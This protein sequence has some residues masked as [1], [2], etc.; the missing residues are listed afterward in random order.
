MQNGNDTP[1]PSRPRVRG[2]AAP[3]GSRVVRRVGDGRAGAP[4]LFRR[5]SV[6]AAL[7]LAF[8]SCM[9]FTTARV[10]HTRSQPA[11][12]LS[13]ALP[14]PTTNPAKYLVLMV[15]DGAR[16]DYFTSTA[17]PHFQQLA[18]AGTQ[19]SAGIDG[20]LEAETP[21]AHTAIATGSRPDHNGILGFDWAN[22]DN[23]RYSLFN[24]DKMNELEQI[25][26]DNHAPTIAGLYKQKY[27][28]SVAVSMSGS[29]YYAAAPLGGPTADAIIY[30]GGVCVQHGPNKNC[31]QS[32]FE[33]YGV[34]G[35][36]PP[37][38]V[39]K[40]P[41]LT[42]H[43]TKLASGQEDHTVTNM[44]LATISQM[45]PRLLLMNYPEFDWPLGHVFGG[46]ADPSLVQ[47]DMRD[48]DTD[49]GQIEDAY[50]RAGI[51]NQTLFV[52]T[53]DHGMMPIERWV[54]SATIDN[55]ITAAGTTSPDVASN[56]GDY[57][58]LADPTKAQTVAD[59]IMNANDPGIMCAYYLGGTTTAPAYSPS[60]SCNVDPAIETANQYLLS[61]L[62]NGHEPQVVVLGNEGVSFSDPVSTHWKG[63]HGGAS[64][65]SQH[66]PLI[67]A[68][69]GVKQGV[70][71][72]SPVQTED[73]APTVLAAM[74]VT[75]TGMDGTILSD[76]LQQPT[77]P[78]TKARNGEITWLTP[79]EQALS[80][81]VPMSPSS[82]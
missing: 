17:L 79:I 62:L 23:D 67:L 20:L 82:S 61:A 43:T 65:E 70:T 40:D 41:S 15:L 2:L 26:Q 56:S 4:A 59:N 22:T 36:M 31:T 72:D 45:H 51:L 29:K 33:P 64:W 81:E 38:T 37:S 16:P 46:S 77:D 78:E 50:R 10:L 11:V 68:G 28:G 25:I 3:S 35:H 48:W 13:S 57:V 1:E 69:P 6:A 60:S 27:P 80:T 24:P 53:A 39:L 75:P 9:A 14:A 34:P 76:A 32:W 49:L 66:F 63:D 47:T 8:A 58:W 73:I 19:F 54:P 21:A 52:I 30:Y 12:I 42:V 71:I 55:A 5:F 74:G 44:A 7:Y 18:D